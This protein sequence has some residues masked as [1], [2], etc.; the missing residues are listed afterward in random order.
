MKIAL[1]SARLIDRDMPYNRKQIER[2][3]REAK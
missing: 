1:A 3:A 2:Y